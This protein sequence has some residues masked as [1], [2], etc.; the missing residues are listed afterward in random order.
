MQFAYS[1]SHWRFGK[2]EQ[3]EPGRSTRFV[4]R[5]ARNFSS[6]TYD[7]PQNQLIILIEIIEL[8]VEN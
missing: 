6:K 2:R 7:V 3:Q 5:R 8:A 4:K 1:Q